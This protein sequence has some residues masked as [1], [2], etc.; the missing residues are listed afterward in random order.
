MRILCLDVGEK[1]IGAAVSDPLGLTA[2]GIDVIKRENKHKDVLKIKDLVE[3]YEVQEILLGY[4]VN[5]N[6]TIGEKA[7]EV[8]NFKKM[9]EKNFSIPVSLW[10]ERLTTSAARR[11]LLEADVSRSARKKVIDKLA[12]VY[13][14]NS[15]LQRKNVEK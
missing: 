4:P 9:L 8:E 10:D 2:Q 5:L 15:Y 14:L 3:N 1:N 6:G 12:A 11:T 13:I 7:R